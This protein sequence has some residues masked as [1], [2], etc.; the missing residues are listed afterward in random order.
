MTEEESVKKIRTLDFD[1]ILDHVGPLGRYQWVQLT[2]LFILSLSS[3]IAVT[4]FAFTGFVPNHRCVIPQC[5]SIEN[6]MTG[7]EAL[8]ELVASIVD[9]KTGK[10]CKRI[11]VP[12]LDQS[13]SCSDYQA[14]LQSNISQSWV[15]NVCSKEELI[16][17]TSVVK[18][19]LVEYYGMTCEHLMVRSILN[20]LYLVGMLLGSFT[21]GLTC[22]RFGR[23]AGM[24]LSITLIS[25]SGILAAF[26]NNQYVFA[27]LRITVGMGG[28]GSYIV[29]SVIAAEA[30]L[31]SL[32]IVTTVY[33]MA[34]FILGELTLSLEAYL[35]RYWFTLQLVAHLPM[36][37]LFSYYFL[38]P[39]STRW[40][41]TKGM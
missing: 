9:D 13:A 26:V 17:D 31:P 4:T 24:M 11:T 25:G 20:S 3:G 23:K 6:P 15:V 40:L 22:D 1:K 32:K 38:I 33:I 16:F 34:G 39:E 36:L 27:A 12:S 35:V 8:Q 5:E 14:A 10:T 7:N 19:S 30:T 28:I 2:L 21:V 41:I 18:T 29:S 37:A